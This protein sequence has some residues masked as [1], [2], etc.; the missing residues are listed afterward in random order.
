[1]E[2]YSEDKKIERKFKIRKKHYYDKKRTTK[3]INTKVK[4]KELSVLCKQM[5]ILLQSGCEITRMLD[6]LAK[7]SNS[8]I[9][10]VLNIVSDNIKQGSSI[11]ESFQQTQV[12]S[13]FFISMVRA[14]EVS[15]SL[16]GV[17][18]NLA[19]YYTKEYKMK[20][21]I[22]NASIYPIIVVSFS[23]ISF[24]IIMVFL[25]PQFE[26]MFAGNGINPPF[27]TKILI[28]IS[29]FI[30]TKYMYM[31]IIILGILIILNFT[32]KKVP[33]I[34]M[35]NLKFKIPILK[36]INQTIA[37]TRFCKTLGMLVKSGIQIVE[38]IDI[39]SKVIDSEY[40]YEK[41]FIAKEYIQ[42]GNSVGYSLE[43]SNVFP[44]L[45]IS[46]INVGEESGRLD[47]C[48][49][50]TEEFYNNELDMKTEKIAKSIEPA[51]IIILA[52]FVGVFMIAMVIPM[53]DS[54]TSMQI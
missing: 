49:E 42:K 9:S 20:S 51:I 29:L 23:I 54:I 46:M 41:L 21:K 48:L 39:S 26:I 22:R 28:K 12:F 53:F 27:I 5:G 11:A 1:M 25:I 35:D 34:K 37:T 45:F 40:I 50:T 8:N 15:G 38:G 30:R 16:D 33:K 44:I 4:D 32:S 47:N 24:A 7:Q 6:I 19:D 13:M 14:G 10:K 18:H 3:T 43:K 36:G 52:F 31:M 17:M 2:S